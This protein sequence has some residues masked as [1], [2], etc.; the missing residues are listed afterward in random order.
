[1]RRW[2]VRRARRALSL[3]VGKDDEERQKEDRSAHMFLS[4]VGRNIWPVEV[5]MTI[6][7]M[8]C[9]LTQEGYSMFIPKMLAMTSP[10]RAAVP[11]SVNVL[12]ASALRLAMLD[13]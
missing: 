13:I 4:C 6:A 7:N 5:I 1:M 11:R 9:D 2:V 12:V 10:G 3:T 8:E